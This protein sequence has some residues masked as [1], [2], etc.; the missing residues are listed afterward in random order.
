MNISIKKKAYFV[1]IMNTL[2]CL[3]PLQNQGN[4]GM[5]LP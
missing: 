3:L 2:Y 4:Q 1:L 5:L